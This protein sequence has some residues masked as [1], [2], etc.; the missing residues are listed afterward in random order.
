MFNPWRLLTMIENNQVRIIKELERMSQATDDLTAATA[1][2]VDREDAI[3]KA[4]NDE[5]ATIADLTAQLAAIPNV[6]P[7]VKDATDKITAS[8]A[9][10][11][12]AIN[13]SSANPAGPNA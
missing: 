7:V 8:L 12:A 9:K 6:D 4:F 2:L 11:D 1:K 13:P 5:K 3:I 10:I